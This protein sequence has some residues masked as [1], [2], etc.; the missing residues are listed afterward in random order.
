MEINDV[1]R[2]IGSALEQLVHGGLTI[3]PGLLDFGLALLI[4]L[5]VLQGLF[6]G[7]IRQIGSLLGLFVGARLGI[8]HMDE[9]GRAVG[10]VVDLPAELVPYVGFLLV[11]LSVRLAADLLALLGARGLGWVGF[12]AADRIIGGA[13]GGFRTALTA[14]I[15]LTVFGFLGIPDQQTQARSQWYK[16]VKET[17]PVTWSVVRS[18]IPEIGRLSNLPDNLSTAMQS[19][20]RETSGYGGAS[21]PTTGE[22]GGPWQVPTSP[23][24]RP[25]SPEPGPPSPK[26]G[27]NGT[28]SEAVGNGIEKLIEKG[29][30]LGQRLGEDLSRDHWWNRPG[31]RMGTGDRPGRYP[32]Q[33][34]PLPRRYGRSG[35][36][37]GPPRRASP[38]PPARPYPNRRPLPSRNG[39][40]GN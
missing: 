19:T 11:L 24:T 30:E 32:K 36:R 12:G 28:L 16:P 7:G 33:E 23:D 3:G 31:E 22:S 34:R 1:L 21:G 35:G 9:A 38:P 29:N 13:L 4:G 18:V 39:S 27:P 6:R 10:R 26:T 25:P 2:P 14:S 5:G 40:G 8:T 17:L 37:A 15:F 20:F